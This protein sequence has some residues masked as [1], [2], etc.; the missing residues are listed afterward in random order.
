MDDLI[1]DIQCEEVYNPDLAIGGED[2][3]QSDI[4]GPEPDSDFPF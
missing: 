2:K 3:P 4:T 1:T